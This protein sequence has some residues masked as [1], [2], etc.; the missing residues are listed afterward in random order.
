MLP[1][2]R[3]I[4]QQ[5]LMSRGRLTVNVIGNTMRWLNGC[6]FRVARYLTKSASAGLVETFAGTR[7]GCASLSSFSRSGWTTMLCFSFWRCRPNEALYSGCWSE[8]YC[9]EQAYWSLN[10]QDIEIASLSLSGEAQHLP[11][12]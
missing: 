2:R 9:N 4:P 8:E 7:H 1:P 6:A 3:T 5:C 10:A 11:I 12:E